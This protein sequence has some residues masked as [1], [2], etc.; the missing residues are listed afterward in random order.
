LIAKGNGIFASAGCEQIDL[1]YRV[2]R[3]IFD[4]QRFLQFFGI[5]NEE[6]AKTAS[7]SCRTLEPDKLD[8]HIHFHW[9]SSK[10]SF[11]LYV[12]FHVGAFRE[13]EGEREPYAERFMPWLGSFLANDTAHA[14]IHVEF[15]YKVEG[16]RSRF[17]LPIKVNLSKDDLEAEVVGI[18]VLFASAPEGISGAQVRQGKKNLTIELTGTIRTNFSA[19]DIKEEVARLS[20]LSMRITEAV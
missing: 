14:D 6:E 20:S 8:Y 11:T 17:P 3:D 18:D 7:V 10:D 12:S 13:S 5:E 19:F 16:M 9:N 4:W 15:E 1:R 2:S